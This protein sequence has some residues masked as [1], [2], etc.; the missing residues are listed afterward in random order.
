[1]AVG[2][3]K[4]FSRDRGFGFIKPTDGTNDGKDVFVHYSD[5]EGDGF[6]TLID[7][8]HVEF[9]ASSGPQGIKAK[10]VRVTPKEKD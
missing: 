4:W 7:G 5:I 3:V 6:K 2:I 1:M 8:Q 9:D 10:N